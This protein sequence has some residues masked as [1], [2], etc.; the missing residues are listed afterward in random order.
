MGRVLLFLAFVAAS[1]LA[2]AQLPREEFDFD[3]PSGTEIFGGQANE[4]EVLFTF[5]F[6]VDEK[7]YLP[8]DRDLARILSS[9]PDV[10]APKGIRARV[11]SSECEPRKLLVEKRGMIVEVSG[12]QIVT[13]LELRPRAGFEKSDQ[14]VR[15]EYPLINS[16][17]AMLG[18]TP[19]GKP[20]TTFSVHVWPSAAAK[21]AVIAAEEEKLQQQREAEERAR[22]AEWQARIA[23]AARVRREKEAKE[24]ARIEARARFIRAMQPYAAA[25]LVL[26]A[27]F[28]IWRK[29][30]YPDLEVV[31]A[32]GGHV[33]KTLPAAAIA[34]AVAEP[35][36]ITQTAWAKNPFWRRRRIKLETFVSDTSAGP[37]AHRVDLLVSVGKSVR[38]GRYLAAVHDSAVRVTVLPA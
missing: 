13:K 12:A 19:P 18:A 16:V 2:R 36:S 24:R 5:Y 29:W 31:L 20:G 10:T 7:R 6:P 22:E 3:V 30:F 26:A 25:M 9:E 14:T 11:V 27:I 1:L 21:Q 37:G 8:V 32:A 15:V 33:Q 17:F 28:M 38:P 4:V 34:E 23:E 35:G